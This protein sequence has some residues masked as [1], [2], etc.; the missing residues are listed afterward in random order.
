MPETNTSSVD[1]QEVE[2]FEAMADLW[3][4][5][6]GPFKPLHKFNPVRLA[7]IREHVAGHW[8]RDPT[9]LKPLTGLRLLDIGC[10]GGLMSE[11]MC[12]LGARVTGIDPSEKNTGT[13]QLHATQMSLEIDY[14]AT[15]AEDLAAAGEQFDVV[16]N[17][18]VVEHVADVQG[19]MNASA[20]LLVPGGI[21]ICATISRTLKS[22]AMAKIGAEYILR[23]LPAGTHDWRKF[24][25]PSELTGHLR[26]A[27]LSVTKLQ[28]LSYSPL[29]DAWGRSGDLNVNYMLVAVKPGQG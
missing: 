10:G 24:L 3:W 21:M 12:R 26:E 15:T 4:D 19:F 6:A 7:F 8:D 2:R 23:W 28:G 27:G 5:A 18:E 11:P 9:S 13:A 16:L 29:K 14:R 22:L 17:L 20:E 25:T 1:P